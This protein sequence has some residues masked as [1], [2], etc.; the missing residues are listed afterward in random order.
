MQ[1]CRIVVA[2]DSGACHGLVVAANGVEPGLRQPARRQRRFGT[3][4]HQVTH[5]EQ[6]IAV[7]VKTDGAQT[8]LEHRKMAVNVAHGE[9]TALFIDGV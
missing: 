4:V 3:S 8:R 5:R 9:I 7:A 1:V 6:A 2:S